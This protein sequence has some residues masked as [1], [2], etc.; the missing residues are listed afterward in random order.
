[1]LERENGIFTKLQKGFI[2]RKRLRTLQRTNKQKQNYFLNLFNAEALKVIDLIIYG[3]FD[4]MHLL[5]IR[6]CELGI[7]AEKTQS[8]DAHYNAVQVQVKFL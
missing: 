6:A 5:E 1:M 3:V 8:T 2:G 7:S 4:L